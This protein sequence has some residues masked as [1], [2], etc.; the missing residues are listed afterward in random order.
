MPMRWYTRLSRRVGWSVQWVTRAASSESTHTATRTVSPGGDDVNV[1]Q[2]LDGV[3]D[4]IVA[5]GN[6]CG[7][8]AIN[9]E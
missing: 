4:S 9:R 8:S 3:V 2:F 6:D 7:F 1:R 5:D